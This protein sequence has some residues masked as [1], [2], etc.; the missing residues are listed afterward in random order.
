MGGPGAGEARETGWCIIGLRF[1]SGRSCPEQVGLGRGMQI[2]LQ[3]RYPSDSRRNSP[4]YCEESSGSLWSRGFSEGPDAVSLDPEN[5]GE[6][7]T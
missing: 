4:I 2:R 3:S 5:L 7:Y 1:P 6:S